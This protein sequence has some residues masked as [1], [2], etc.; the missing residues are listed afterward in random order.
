MRRIS[1]TRT[2]HD[3]RNPVGYDRTQERP[4]HVPGATVTSWNG[5][6][7]IDLDAL[8]AKPAGGATVAGGTPGAANHRDPETVSLSDGTR[9]TF[10]DP[11]QFRPVATV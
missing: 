3:E 9:I 4:L 6:P 8:F 5:S 11:D 2:G 1:K 7:E 10:A